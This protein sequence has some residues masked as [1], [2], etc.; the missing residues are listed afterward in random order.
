MVVVS[1]DWLEHEAEVHTFLRTNGL[2]MS[3]QSGPFSNTTCTITNWKKATD[4]WPQ[5]QQ[6]QTQQQQQLQTLLPNQQQIIIEDN[7]GPPNVVKSPQAA[8]AVLTCHPSS[9]QFQVNLLI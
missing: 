3:A 2:M 7:Q 4:T 9:H 5:Q 8:L 1:N 6:Q